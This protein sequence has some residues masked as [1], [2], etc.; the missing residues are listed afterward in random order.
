MRRIIHGL[1]LMFCLC[2]TSLSAL[3]AGECDGRKQP[4]TVSISESGDFSLQ[5]SKVSSYRELNEKLAAMGFATA[6]I[7]GLTM[8]LHGKWQ[9]KFFTLSVWSETLEQGLS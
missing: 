1:V 3:A 8:A 9:Q 7:S 5:E 4:L 6:Y 2:G